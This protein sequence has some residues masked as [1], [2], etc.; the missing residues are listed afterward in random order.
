MEKANFL[1]SS[2]E[3]K[4][5][6][7]AL[8]NE[9]SVGMQRRVSLARTL[10]RKAELYVFDEPMAGLDERMRNISCDLI[11]KTIPIDSTAIIISHDTKEIEKISD[12]KLTLVNRKISADKS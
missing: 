9:L 8:P 3:L 6:S 2:L 5:E 4:N 1:L 12:F 10:A 11:R 7:K